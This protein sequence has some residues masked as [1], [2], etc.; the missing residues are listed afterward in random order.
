[1][2]QTEKTLVKSGEER[3]KTDWEAEGKRVLL[4]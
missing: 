1:M 4:K 3:S 2:K